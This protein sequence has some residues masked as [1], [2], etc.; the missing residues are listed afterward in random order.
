MVRFFR[1]LLATAVLCV[2]AGAARAEPPVWVVR[3]GATTITLFGSVHLLPAGLDWEPARLKTAIAGADDLWFEIPIDEAS[4]L[5]AARAALA[6]G[7]QPPG[8]TLRGQLPPAD[9]PRLAK[10][11][12][13]CG[14]PLDRLDRLKPWLAEITLSV[15]EYRQVGALQEDG[16]ERTLSTSSPPALIRHA[17]ETPEQQIGYLS[18]AALPDQ[19]AS[20]E[21]TL[22]EL[23]EGPASYQRLV[24][25]WMAGNTAA[26]ER[27]AI[28]PLK[29]E[30]PGVYRTLVVD[31]NRRWIDA[32]LARLSQPGESVMV[33]G[34]GHL[35]G[36]DSLP[37]MLRARGLTVEG[38]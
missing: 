35:V 22:G 3:Q 37:A 6:Q 21:E 15:A 1:V 12:A 30:A 24:K 16:V 4:A 33:V 5:T 8:V 9:L 7:L 11:A 19:I 36:A 25:A 34:V 23:E 10:I 14:L 31:R 28:D 2:L 20:L 38:P 13:G 27:E 26:I 29:A 17:F 32:I 18:G